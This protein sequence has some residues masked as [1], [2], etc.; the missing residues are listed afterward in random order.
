MALLLLKQVQKPGKTIAHKY[1]FKKTYSLQRMY[2]SL[3][4]GNV[5]PI[6]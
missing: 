5:G 2:K 6:Y 1:P 3:L 4:S